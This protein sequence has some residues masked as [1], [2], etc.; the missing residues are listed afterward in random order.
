MRCMLEVL[1]K[2]ARKSSI[3]LKSELYAIQDYFFDVKIVKTLCKATGLWPNDQT[4]LLKPLIYAFKKCLTA[5]ALRK[6]LLET[7][8]LLN[9]IFENIKTKYKAKHVRETMFDLLARA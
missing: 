1:V 5:L 8:D 2:I 7:L 4:F 9:N 3:F 6:T